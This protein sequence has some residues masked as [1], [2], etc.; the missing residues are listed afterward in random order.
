MSDMPG[1]R[2]AD[3]LAGAVVEP[4]VMGLTFVPWNALAGTGGVRGAVT[5]MSRACADAHLD[6]VFVP[7]WEGGADELVT[8]ARAT[9]AE[10]VWVVP[11]VLS[12]ALDEIGIVAGLRAVARETGSLDA[13]LDEAVDA[14]LEAVGRGVALGASAIAVADDIAG[15]GGPFVSPEYA[16]TALLPRYA[17]LT[18]AAA[19]AG[20]PAI[21]HSDGE[22]RIPLVDL[23]A[24]G[25]TALHAGGMADDAFE[26]LVIEA[27]SAGLAVLG[28]IMTRDLDAGL[29]R[30][31]L[32]GTR[33]GILARA[34]GLLLADDGGVT[35]FEQY[36]ALLGAFAAA[37][38]P[39]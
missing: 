21:L 16:A 24:A 31:V 30:A 2:F 11:G 3:A 36:A 7:S 18:A 28:G 4:L 5:A 20:L 17:K 29:P 33:A 10:P 35:A 9:C 25:F 27:R 39:G 22:I 37:R 32:A 23:R 15:A 8:A 13:A 12:P 26:A 1:T 14:A 38:G 19:E 34:G 6:F